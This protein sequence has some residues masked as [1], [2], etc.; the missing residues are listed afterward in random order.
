M[1]VS[2]LIATLHHEVTKSYTFIAE[3]KAGVGS[4]ASSKLHLNIESLE[5]ELPVALSQQEIEFNPKDV[6]GQP[7]AFKK[8]FMPFTHHRDQIPQKPIIGKAI[9]AEVV[10]PV[11][12]LD[13]RVSAESLGR[14]KVVFK[15]V[16]S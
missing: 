9:M 6:K 4:T 14:I 16:V 3:T 11:E 10:G 15:V 12:K 7:N 5:I 8:L 13:D 2:E 1:Q